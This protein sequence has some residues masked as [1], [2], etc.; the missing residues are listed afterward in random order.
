[1]AE[2]GSRDA[3]RDGAWQDRMRA[4]LRTNPSER[5]GESEQ[6]GE[7]ARVPAEGTLEESGPHTGIVHPEN[8]YQRSHPQAQFQPQSQAHA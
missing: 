5:P 2:Q 8:Q 7:L 3:G 6:T 4:L 1:M